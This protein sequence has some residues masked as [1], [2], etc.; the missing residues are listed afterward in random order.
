MEAP[1]LQFKEDIEVSD[2]YYCHACHFYN[3]TA[4]LNRGTKV[5]FTQNRFFL[6][7]INIMFEHDIYFI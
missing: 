1:L 2:G 5:I 7:K 4:E 6:N 3:F